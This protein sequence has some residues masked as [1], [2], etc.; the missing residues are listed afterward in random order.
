[1]EL[2]KLIEKPSGHEEEI[3]TLEHK[4]IQYFAPE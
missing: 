2:S 4:Y 1:M 3:E